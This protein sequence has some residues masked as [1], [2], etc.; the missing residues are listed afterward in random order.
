MSLSLE[1]AAI[2]VGHQRHDLRSPMRTP[3]DSQVGIA[4]LPVTTKPAMAGRRGVRKVAIHLANTIL[5]VEKKADFSVEKFPD[6][7]YI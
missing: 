1:G 6:C 3:C 4:W 7:F 5:R 2:P